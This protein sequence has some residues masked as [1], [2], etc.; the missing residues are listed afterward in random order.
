MFPLV[1][2]W[3]FGFLTGLLAVGTLAKATMCAPNMPVFDMVIELIPESLLNPNV[4][5]I[6]LCFVIE[7]LNLRLDT[8][9]LAV[10]VE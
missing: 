7:R 6:D 8:G 1:F 5:P 10:E 2:G 3:L 4:S 9:R